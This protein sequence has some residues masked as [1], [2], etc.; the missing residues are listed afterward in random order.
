MWMN[1]KVIGWLDP[2]QTTGLAV[3]VSKEQRVVLDKIDSTSHREFYTWQVP[4]C[5]MDEGLAGLYDLLALWTSWSYPR[6]PGSVAKEVLIGIESFDFRMQERYRDKIDYTAPEIIGAVRCWALDRSTV[7]L[8]R[9]PAAL[10]KGFWT[11]EKLQRV[12]LYVPNAPHAMD[13]LR[14]LLRYLT[15]ESTDKDA[16]KGLFDKLKA[17]G[18]VNVQDV[19]K[20]IPEDPYL[21]ESGT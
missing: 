6:M 4:N 16:A 21:W 17:T 12:D 11:N 19:G 13:A 18:P 14:H 10:G 2:G 8:K 1:Y 3:W 15:F 5:H 7:E 9:A 20:T